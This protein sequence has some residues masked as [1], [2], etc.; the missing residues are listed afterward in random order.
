MYNYSKMFFQLKKKCFL[1]FLN[2]VVLFFKFKFKILLID[3]ISLSN[4]L[5]DHIADDKNLKL[6]NF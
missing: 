6:D 2:F 1:L 5:Q 3:K 4:F